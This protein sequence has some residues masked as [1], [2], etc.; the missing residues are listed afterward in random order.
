MS[1][2]FCMTCERAYPKE[3]LSFVFGNFYKCT[4]RARCATIRV[5]ALQRR[6]HSVPP[7][8]AKIA[9]GQSV[10]VRMTFLE[11]PPPPPAPVT[12]SRPAPKPAK[13][14]KLD[15]ELSAKLEMELGEVVSSDMLAG[16]DAL[17]D[18]MFGATEKRP[19]QAP[20]LDRVQVAA[21]R[22]VDDELE[23]TPADAVEAFREP[24]AVV[25][26][27]TKV[28]P[29]KVAKKPV[30]SKQPKKPA[31]KKPSAP[32]VAAV[33][34]KRRGP[35]PDTLNDKV[36]VAITDRVRRDG[37]LY[38]QLACGHEQKEP[39]GGKAHLAKTAY[40]QVCLLAKASAA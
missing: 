40:C 21:K 37:A 7:D 9:Q 33:S 8:L 36:K 1:V 5:E 24:E 10:P 23:A 13:P 38:R 12:V 20:E 11:A 39:A 19:S 17:F 34:T 18:D 30:P 27:E 29:L 2:Y 15:M 26:P 35:P 14:S 25:V 31:A 4:D 16:V 3:E 28:A 32:K 6:G 22:F